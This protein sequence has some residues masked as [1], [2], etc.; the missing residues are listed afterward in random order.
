MTL[1]FKLASFKTKTLAK[2]TTIPQGQIG[3]YWPKLTLTVDMPMRLL[4]EAIYPPSDSNLENFGVVQKFVFPCAPKGRPVS[5]VKVRLMFCSISVSVH[6]DECH[7]ENDHKINTVFSLIRTIQF[8]SI[9]SSGRPGLQILI[10]TLLQLIPRMS[11]N[12][13][14]RNSGCD[15]R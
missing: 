6:M 10:L 3:H 7:L 11:W 12:Q 8:H 15:N 13:D 4:K 5:Q 9:S 1:T 2:R 14:S